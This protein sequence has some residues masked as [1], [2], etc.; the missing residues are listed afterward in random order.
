MTPTEEQYLL[1]VTNKEA[2]K[3]KQSLISV[4]K[5]VGGGIGSQNTSTTAKLNPLLGSKEIISVNEL[6]PHNL[7]NDIQVLVEFLRQYYISE[8]SSDLSGISAIFNTLYEKRDIDLLDIENPNILNFWTKE[9]SKTLSAVHDLKIDPRTF[10]KHART[11]YREKGSQNGIKSFFRLLFNADISVYLPWEDVLIASDGKWDD[12]TNS[13]VALDEHSSEL[14]GF[15]LSKG[16]F[17]IND[18]FLSDKIYLQDSF[19]YQQYSYD[20]KSGVPEQ[21]WLSLFKV[22]MHPAG[23]IV[24]STL[25]LTIVANNAKMPRSQAF[26]YIEGIFR[27]VLL[28]IELDARMR[29]QIDSYLKCVSII[30][31]ALYFCSDTFNRFVFHSDTPIEEYPDLSISELESIRFNTDSI[32]SISD[33]DSPIS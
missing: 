7:R 2:L 5:V 20:I 29:T 15:T 16:N 31:N 19:Y 13:K 33:L 28:T 27:K 23:F 21:E 9:F 4:G 12:T 24:F 6:F 11:L 17:T 1:K 26:G 14:K 18:G 22:L 30:Q 3:S 32:I 25:L 8:N 10:L